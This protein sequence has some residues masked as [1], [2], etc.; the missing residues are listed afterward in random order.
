MK[1]L[2]EVKI[3]FY[4]GDIW[5]N[6]ETYK[7][8]DGTGN[9]EDGTINN[10]SPL[11]LKLSNCQVG[12]IIELLEGVRCKIEDVS[13]EQTFPDLVKQ[14]T[15]YFNVQN[16]DGL[17]D[18]G[19]KLLKLLSKTVV[20]TREL[21]TLC[22]KVVSAHLTV[23]DAQKA[24]EWISQI[25]DNKYDLAQIK[26]GLTQIIETQGDLVLEDI[27]N[28]FLLNRLGLLH[29][30]LNAFRKA[31]YIYERSLMIDSNNVYTYNS[32]GSVCKEAG[33]HDKAIYNYNRGLMISDN[34]VSLVGLGATYRALLDY[35]T[36]LS[37]YKHALIIDELD[38]YAN[39]GIGATY[40][41]LG[42]YEEGSKHF[43]IAGD[44]K[45][46]LDLFWEY[47]SSGLIESALQCLYLILKKEPN[48]PTASKLMLRY[49]SI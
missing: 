34:I 31:S 15:Q 9:P 26:H 30:K 24:I 33:W 12:D 4:E 5:G 47:E 8:V 11:A 41:D 23:N 40:F 36:S 39:N 48:H 32:L 42:M 27:T 1:V 45:P 2:E 44:T 21:D 22:L 7:I 20:T 17:I 16:D 28:T 49:N 13:F 38:R 46:I 3:R 29:K 19:W 43:L 6:V 18:I 25:T 10:D 37:Y 14:G 35:D